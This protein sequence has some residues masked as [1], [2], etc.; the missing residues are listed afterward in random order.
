MELYKKVY[1]K[2]EED[3]PK[4]G[5]YITRFGSLIYRNELWKLPDGD[6][7]YLDFTDFKVDWYLQPIE[8]PSDEEIENELNKVLPERNNSFTRGYENGWNEC[9][10]W[11]REQFKAK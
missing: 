10:K 5:I 9:A 7:S 1:I 11:M 4:K 2:S 6:R 3:L 8:L